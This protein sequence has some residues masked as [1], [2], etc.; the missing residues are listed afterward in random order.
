MVWYKEIVSAKK[1]ILSDLLTYPMKIMADKCSIVWDDHEALT[2]LLTEGIHLIPYGHLLYAADPNGTQISANVHLDRVDNT[3][4]SQDLSHRPYLN[5]IL[6]YR[7]LV[8]SEAYLSQQNDE[9]CI[10]AIQA[11]VREEQLLGFIAIDFNIKDLPVENSASKFRQLGWQQFRGDPVIRQQVFHQERVPSVF[12]ENIDFLNYV[13]AALLQEHGVFHSKMHFSSSRCTLW[14]KEDPYNYRPHCLEELMSPDLFFVYTKQDYPT[15]AVVP[16]EKVPL[17][18]EQFKALRQGD[19]TIYLRSGSVNIMNGLIGLTFSCDG[20]H[21]MTVD[22][23]LEKDLS[24]WYGPAYQ[25]SM[26]NIA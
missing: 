21:Y 5:G 17:I 8:L 12:D 25:C 6:P 19:D 23:F 14:S 7:G 10:T 9:P 1:Q 13:I 11:V 26:P 3:R 4:R 22:E 18:F 24:F 20:S 2:V 16:K 15:K